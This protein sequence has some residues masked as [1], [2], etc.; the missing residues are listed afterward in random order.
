MNVTVPK[1]R[2]SLPLSHSLS[3]FLPLPLPPW[4]ASTALTT[5]RERESGAGEG[6]RDGEGPGPGGDLRLDWKSGGTGRAAVRGGAVSFSKEVCELYKINII[7][8]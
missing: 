6:W 3:P 5:Q 7:N 4:A 2:C 1:L 8:G